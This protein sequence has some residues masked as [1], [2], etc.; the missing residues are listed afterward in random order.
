MERVNIHTYKEHGNVFTTTQ[1]SIKLTESNFLYQ[2]KEVILILLEHKLLRCSSLV[3][4]FRYL[5]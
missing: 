4:F 1:L 3:K 5:K 2:I